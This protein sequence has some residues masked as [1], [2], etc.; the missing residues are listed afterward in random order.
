VSRPGEVHDP[1]ERLCWLRSPVCLEW[2]EEEPGGEVSPF[3]FLARPAR[4]VGGALVQVLGSRQAERVSSTANQES[5]E[6]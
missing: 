1:Y 6:V 2:R 5:R 4:K 3:H